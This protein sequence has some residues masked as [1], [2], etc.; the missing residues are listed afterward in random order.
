[1][2]SGYQSKNKLVTVSTDKT[3]KF[4]IFYYGLWKYYENYQSQKLC[5]L[6]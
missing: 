6:L 3:N 5:N 1:M 2:S 4:N